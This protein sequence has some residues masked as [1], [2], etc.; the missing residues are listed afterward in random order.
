MSNVGTPPPHNLDKPPVL[1]DSINNNNNNNNKSNGSQFDTDISRCFKQEE[2]LTYNGSNPNPEDWSEYLKND[3]DFQEE[4]DNI[5]NNSNI[6]EAD[7]NFTL[8]VFGDTYLNMELDISIYGD[9]PVFANMTKRFREKDG[10]L[11]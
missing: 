2:D 4:F 9:S 6:P 11:I 3:L 1:V 5:I 7:A 8:D 10:L